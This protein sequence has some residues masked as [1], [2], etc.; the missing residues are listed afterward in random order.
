MRGHSR[1]QT[2]PG[3]GF[4]DCGL[5]RNDGGGVSSHKPWSRHW[6]P[7]ASSYRLRISSLRR[8]PQ[9]RT[10]RCRFP[11]WLHNNDGKGFRHDPTVLILNCP[12]PFDFP[13]GERASRLLR[14]VD[15]RFR[16]S[17]DEGAAGVTR[18]GQARQGRA[19]S[20][21][22]AMS[23]CR[24]SLSAL[25]R[26][27]STALKASTVKGRQVLRRARMEPSSRARAST[28]RVWMGWR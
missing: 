15:S 6:V 26:S 4:L 16:G 27:W 22:R 18:V 8:R 2:A 5:R 24:R 7:H 10:E 21:C 9:S 11:G 28:S 1:S 3:L 12:F 25:R 14:G 23:A 13:Q 19:R 17:D 20:S